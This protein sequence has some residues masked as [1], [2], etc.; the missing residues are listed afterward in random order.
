MVV[1]VTAGLFV[2]EAQS[3]EQLVLDGSMVEASTT[4]QRHHLLTTTTA[5]VGVAAGQDQRRVEEHRSLRKASD[6]NS[7]CNISLLPVLGLDAQPVAVAAPAGPE[8]DAGEGREGLQS[9]G[10]DGLLTGGWQDHTTQQ[11]A[12]YQHAAQGKLMLE[13]FLTASVTCV[14]AN[15]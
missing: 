11:L 4:G 7:L 6:S 5:D 14:V 8:A 2:V 3:V 13:E 9:T 1:P 12:F 10:D 15:D